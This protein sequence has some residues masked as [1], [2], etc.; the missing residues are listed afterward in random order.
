[1][2]RELSDAA[3]QALAEAVSQGTVKP[4]KEVDALRAE[5]DRL[6]SFLGE[7]ADDPTGVSSYQ[8]DLAKRALAGEPALLPSQP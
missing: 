4:V 6:R 2:T 7:I 8:A 3:K 1:M 5:I